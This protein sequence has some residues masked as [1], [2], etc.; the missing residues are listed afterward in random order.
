LSKALSSRFDLN[1]AL[2]GA[3]Y[4]GR[5]H[6]RVL[7]EISGHFTIADSNRAIAAEIASNL[8][9]VSVADSPEHVIND[10]SIDAVV[11]ATP[12]STHFEIARDCMLAGKHVLV[13]KPLAMIP[14]DGAELL[15]VAAETGKILMVGHL[16]LYHPAVEKLLDLTSDGFLGDLR[17]TYS[18]RLNMGKVR[19]EENALWSFAPHDVSIINSVLKEQPT[20]V[21]CTGGDYLQNGIADV[22]LSAMSYRSGRKAHVFVSWLHPFKERRL[23]VV[24]SE[25]MIVFEDTRT[26]DKLLEYDCDVDLSN[27][28]PVV[29]QSDGVPVDHSDDEPLM[30]ED[31][32]FLQCVIDGTNPL[33]DGQNGL[34]VLQILD[35]CQRSMERGGA[36]VDAS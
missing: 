30:R 27:G 32:H 20:T 28:V 6:A 9:G 13:E 14:S 1:V 18:T 26:E 29:R 21:S 35:A 10:P 36:P 3:G 24:G 5:N 31:Q 34:E 19:I 7:A 22:S 15:K 23:V 2:I 17:Y 16:F 4:W 33:T 8:D 11:I 25:K 12:A